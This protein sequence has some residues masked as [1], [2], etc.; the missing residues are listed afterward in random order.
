MLETLQSANEQIKKQ[1]Y[2][3]TLLGYR[4]SQAGFI[5]SGSPFTVHENGEKTEYHGCLVLGFVVQ[6]KG[7]KEYDLG[8]TIFWD[9][10]QWVI[11]TELSEINDEQGQ[12]IIRELPERKCD[13]LSDCLREILEAVSDLGQFE[14]IVTAFEKGS[15]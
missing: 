14:E 2:K 15:E 4:T 5:L 3:Y 1:K 12:V 6:G 13:K 10:T 11:T 8:L 7:Q 9:A